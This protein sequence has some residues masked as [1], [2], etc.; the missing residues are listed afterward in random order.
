ML[1]KT[2]VEIKKIKNFSALR[3]LSYYRCP[4]LLF[5]IYA[6]AM[7]KAGQKL[8]IAGDWLGV[9]MATQILIS[10]PLRWLVTTSGTSRGS[11]SR[12]TILRILG[13]GSQRLFRKHDDA[14]PLIG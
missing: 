7:S 6:F 11:S 4:T 9:L 2:Q 12:I 14:Q 13:V 8:I 5:D 3:C 1:P 10:K